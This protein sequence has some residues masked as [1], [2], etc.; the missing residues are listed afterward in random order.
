MAIGTGVAQTGLGGSSGYGEITLPR[1]DD[2]A[3]QQDWSA[4]FASGLN[5]LGQN[6]QPNQ[7]FVNTNGVVSFG[8]ALPDFPTAT[9][10]ATTVPMIAP[11]WADVDTRLRGEGVESGAIHVDIDPV[12]DCVSV[13]WDNVGAFRR[14]TEEVN[15]FQL[16]FFDLGNGDFDIVLRYEA[17]NW[18][19][20]SNPADIGVQALLASPRL[21][22]P[23]WLR[24]NESADMLL[25]LDSAL[26]NTG[27][28]GLWVYQMRDGT[29][30]G[31]TPARGLVLYGGEGRDT[32]MG[33]ASSDLMYGRTGADVLRGGLGR[34]TL[35]GNAGDDLLEGGVTEQD[36]RDLL[37]GGLGN[38]T[39]MGGGG[40]DFIQGGAD[41]DL[42][43]GSFGADMLYGQTGNDSIFGGAG[44][45]R[46][47]ASDG[48]D[49]LDGG[50][51]S[52]RLIGGA[53]RDRFYHSG[54]TADGSDWVLDYFAAAG[55][56]LE[57]GLPAAQR[58]QFKLSFS[59]APG[60]GDP[61]VMEV[62]VIYKPTQTTLWALVDGAGQD[63]VNIVLAGQIID[64]F[65]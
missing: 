51:G 28:A 38:D 30:P 54:A 64:L 63:H 37:Y 6:F 35:D 42:I 62:F 17:I 9:S 8:M 48:S 4:V 31:L 33:T 20:G 7:I 32:L 25:D 43:Y 47:F 60:A 12:A 36:L 23:I 56:V 65:G 29:L 34:D 2:G 59:H 58:G 19:T 61:A 14:N 27:I 57:F 15:R 10:L 55:D 1:S 21:E 26:G 53:G 24:P 50:L 18:T 52:D 49:F 45:D 44:S 13:T 40:A 22:H 39:L 16:Q 41:N 5:F 11:F 3:A 46:L